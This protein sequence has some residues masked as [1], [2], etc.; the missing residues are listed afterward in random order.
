MPLLTP[1]L[2]QGRKIML[3][4]QQLIAALLNAAQGAY[5]APFIQAADDY[6]KQNVSPQ[7]ARVPPYGTAYLSNDGG[8][9]VTLHQ[10][11]LGMD[12]DNPLQCADGTLPPGLPTPTVWLTNVVTYVGAAPPALHILTAVL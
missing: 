2:L 10:Y 8:Y 11:N 3:L 12:P 1:T 7:G 4:A 6:I 5:R 9:I